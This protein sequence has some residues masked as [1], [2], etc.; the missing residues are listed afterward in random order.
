MMNQKRGRFE[1][2]RILVLLVLLVFFMQSVAAAGVSR[3]YWDDYP[4]KL[5]P[6]ESKIIQLTLQNT[7]SE[8]IIFKA[9]IISEIAQLNDKSNEYLV[10]SGETEKKV[11]IKVEIPEDAEIGTI[12]KIISSFKEASSGEGGMV[13]MSA[14]FNV[15][16]P[17]EVVG[18]DESA[19]RSEEPAGTFN[20]FYIIIVIGI[21]TLI[22][23]GIYIKKKKK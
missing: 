19:L 1:I 20:W 18:Y 2:K 8:D 16:F 14:A 10:P 15:D 6:G 12:Y 23:T 9:E 13:K 22:G 7:D 17:V 3:P 4:L 5:A 11:N 21:L